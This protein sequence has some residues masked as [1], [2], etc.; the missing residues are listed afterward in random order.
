MNRI[1]FGWAIAGAALLSFYVSTVIGT[2]MLYILGGIVVLYL[3]GLMLIG[4]FSPSPIY[5]SEDMP[6]RTKT[7][8]S[9][10]ADPTSP[11]TAADSPNQPPAPHL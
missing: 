8:N 5:D 3:L 11:P 4:V 9:D 10:S 6:N 2:N 1:P 7:N